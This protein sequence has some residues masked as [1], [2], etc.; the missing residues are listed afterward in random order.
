MS[1]DPPDDSFGMPIPA[2]VASLVYA[3]RI[4]TA[5]HE[6]VRVSGFRRPPG[7]VGCGLGG[8]RLP[9]NADPGGSRMAADRTIVGRR[10]AAE[11]A[12]P[13]DR[14]PRPGRMDIP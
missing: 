8:G 11:A 13:G 4:E 7:A 1:N 2:P 12:R 5:L 6:T 3:P 10:V 9:A 14:Q